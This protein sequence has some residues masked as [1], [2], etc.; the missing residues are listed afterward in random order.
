MHSLFL[1]YFPTDG[2]LGGC[3]QFPPTISNT[4][5]EFFVYTSEKFWRIEP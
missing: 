3:F 1:K 4:K 5:V 2:F